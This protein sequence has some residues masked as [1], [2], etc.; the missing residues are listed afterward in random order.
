MPI[1][2]VHTHHAVKAPHLAA[3]RDVY[4]V[5]FG[6]HRI[7]SVDIT[8][9]ADRGAYVYELRYRGE[10]GVVAST[11]YEKFRSA[12]YAPYR[13]ITL[14]HV[15][16]SGNISDQLHDNTAQLTTQGFFNPTTQSFTGP[17]VVISLADVLWRIQTGRVPVKLRNRP[18]T[19]CTYVEVLIDDLAPYALFV[20]EFK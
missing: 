13:S 15:D 16:A 6:T 9:K 18:R 11:V 2:L 5:V 1:T 3:L 10:F 12:D 8:P 4:P 19:V 14:T 7:T 20:K 17:L